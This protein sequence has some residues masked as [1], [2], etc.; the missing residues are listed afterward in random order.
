MKNILGILILILAIGVFSVCAAGIITSIG[1]EGMAHPILIWVLLVVSLPLMPY[2]A[3][4]MQEG[5]F[6]PGL[7]TYWQYAKGWLKFF[8]V[9]AAI[10]LVTLIIV[11]VT[12]L[13]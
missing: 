9:M 11:G 5:E 10:V 8:G 6:D 2:G 13:L 7:R 12:S 1:G 4:V 3:A